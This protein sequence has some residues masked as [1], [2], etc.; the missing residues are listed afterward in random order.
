MK[1]IMQWVMAATLICG[2]MVFTAC[3]SSDDNPV[4]PDLNVADKIIGKWIIADRNGQPMPTNKKTVNTFVSTTKALLSSSITAQPKIGA[5][6]CEEMEANVVI[7]GNKVTLTC[8]P[9]ETT[10]VL[11][12]TVTTINDKE[13]I[14]NRKV[15]VTIDGNVELFV[16]DVI[17]FER[18]ADYSD[19]IIGLWECTGLTGGETYND[20]NGRL[21]FLAD[22][23]Y[24]YYRQD[25]NGQWQVISNR[26]FQDYFVD[27]TLLATRWKNEGE[28]E[29]REW[30]EID[31]I[32][33]DEM[34]W[35]ALRQNEDKTTFTTTFEMKKV[36]E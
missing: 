17:R 28:D 13:L 25:D 7:N 2:A 14:A 4:I 9:D 26:E 6:W 29:L 36:A 15:T 33:G 12:Y 22:G 32:I 20:A 1:R 23:T 5:I 18:V 31:D 35:T 30:W 34:V 3:S 27:G 11:E 8:Y 24:R 10:S 16:E 19:Q 21:E